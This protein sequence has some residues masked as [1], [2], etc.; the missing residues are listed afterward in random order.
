M[1][2]N[3]KFYYHTKLQ[4]SKLSDAVTPTSE[5]RTASMLVLFLAA[6]QG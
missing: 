3:F 6:N 4:D 2:C 1:E 5:V